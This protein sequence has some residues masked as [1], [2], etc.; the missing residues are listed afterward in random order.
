MNIVHII[1][2]PQL[3]GAEIFACQLA[4]LQ[5]DNGNKVLVISL[6]SA[7]AKLP[8]DGLMV[9]LKAKKRY[10]FIDVKSWAYLSK[11]INEW[12]ADIIQANAGDTLK[13]AVF[14]KLLFGWKGKI[15]FRNANKM[16]GF[17][18]S[19]YQQILNSFLLRKVDAIASVSHLCQEDIVENFKPNCLME[20]IKIGIDQKTIVYLN[21][22][23]NPYP[24]KEGS[25]LLIIGAL[26]PEKGID[27]F[28]EVFKTFNR[29]YP[30]M[31]LVIIGKGPMEH[32]VKNEIKRLNLK[33]RVR[34]L[35]PLSNIFPV[36]SSAKALV[37]PS[38]I[39]GLPAVILESMFC[40][41]PVI[42]Y[43]VGGISEVLISGE[44]GFLVPAG[45]EKA[46]LQ[47][48]VEVMEM[49]T[50]KLEIIIRNA[51]EMISKDFSLC[52]L[53]DEFDQLYAKVIS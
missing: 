19:R 47:H 51:Q 40:K 2:K 49:P 29:N 8:F 17:I 31:D 43:D 52:T 7:E 16:S 22:D 15:V 50:D 38:L 24:L 32:Q 39:E 4:Q 28:L 30:S 33:E 12:D 35:D 41:V 53:R 46:M 3:R 10:R 44:T 9:C 21:N 20:V 11:L 26:V 45:N 5:K 13:Y 48:M 14:S 37:V 42:A 23:I 1:N 25:Y 27:H 18:I 36:I 6:F 34:I